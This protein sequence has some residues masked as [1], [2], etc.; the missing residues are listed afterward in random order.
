MMWYH[1]TY[2]LAWAVETHDHEDS[3]FETVEIYGE[4][5]PWHI[6]PKQGDVLEVLSVAYPG[7]VRIH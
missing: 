7:W 1:Y 2:Q 6:I 3:Y 5:Y 4:G